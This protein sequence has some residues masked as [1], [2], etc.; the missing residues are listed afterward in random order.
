MD[1]M[2]QAE[3]AASLCSA[4]ISAVILL[5]GCSTNLVNAQH[6]SFRLSARLGEVEQQADFSGHCSCSWPSL[7]GLGM[8][9]R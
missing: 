9:R 1:G 4:S 5:L 7:G 6:A 3:V 8:A 2:R